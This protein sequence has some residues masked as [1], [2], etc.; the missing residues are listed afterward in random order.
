MQ[1]LQSLLERICHAIELV[2][3]ALMALITVVIVVSAVSRY[4]FSYPLPDAFD[5]SRYLLGAAI[6]WGFASVGYR[7]S[8]IKVDIVAEIL[9]PAAR[10]WIDSFA[11][12]VLLGFTLLLAWKMLDRVRST[13]R[14][15]EATMDLRLDAWPFYALIWAGVAVSILAILARLIIVA[16]GRGSLDHYDPVDPVD[17]PD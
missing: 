5:L 13:A 17:A 4:L 1:R 3:G 14:S 12:T 16:S 9:P 15:G 6:M 7:G 2:A 10:R 8:H 11:W